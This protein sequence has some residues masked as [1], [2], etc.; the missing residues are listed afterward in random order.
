MIAILVILLKL[1]YYFLD[2]I[3]QKTKNFPF[4]PQNKNF[5][6]DKFTKQMND[7]KP[8]VFT[9]NKKVILWLD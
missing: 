3:K 8:D 5:P 7:F 1:I 4:A 9:K 2:I 6:P